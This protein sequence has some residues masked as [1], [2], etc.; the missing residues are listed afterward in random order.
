[1]SEYRDQKD[2]ADKNVDDTTRRATSGEND[3]GDDDRKVREREQREREERDRMQAR[4]NEDN[5]EG[6]RA[7][8]PS[9][10]PDSSR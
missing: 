5:R 4:D 9:S 1:M 10:K 7:R 6:D 8:T 2:Q 3:M